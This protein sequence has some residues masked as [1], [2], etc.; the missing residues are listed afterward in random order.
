MRMMRRRP[1]ILSTGCVQRF[2]GLVSS[3]YDM[4]DD[5]NNENQAR[6]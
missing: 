3:L 5:K 6:Y 4:K 2:L 1:E